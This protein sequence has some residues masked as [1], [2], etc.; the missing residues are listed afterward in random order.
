MGKTTSIK[1]ILST[2]IEGFVNHSI[3]GESNTKKCQGVSQKFGVDEKK[4]FEKLKFKI[5]KT[6]K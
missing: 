4:S 2:I 1:Q 3:C 6:K 5:D